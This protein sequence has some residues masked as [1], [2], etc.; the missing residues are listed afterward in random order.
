[1][2]EGAGCC[3]GRGGETDLLAE[4][5]QPLP[6]PAPQPNAEVAQ[7]GKRAS[8]PPGAATLLLPTCASQLGRLIGLQQGERR[9]R[10][11]WPLCH[12]QQQPRRWGAAGTLLLKRS[13]SFYRAISQGC[14]PWQSELKWGRQT[15]APS[16]GFVLTDGASAA[17]LWPA[18]S[19]LW[20]WGSP[21]QLSQF[22]RLRTSIE[23][24]LFCCC[25]ANWYWAG[26]LLK[27]TVIA[28]WIG[29]RHTENLGPCEGVY[30]K[31]VKL[32]S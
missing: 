31:H 12:A 26:E 16:R 32:R 27:G 1:M 28:T 22:Q 14:W 9:A 3:P 29:H 18:S 23:Q 19:R 21:A 7:A 11:S 6:H 30:T 8:V 17:R 15:G 2:G 25:F 20:W 10:P 13:C 4:D 5:T 24:L